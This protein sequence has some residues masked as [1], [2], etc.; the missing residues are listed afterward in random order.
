M[1]ALVVGYFSTFGDIEVLRQ[2]ERQLSAVGMPYDIHAY[3][4]RVR[5]HFRGTVDLKTATPEHYTHLLLVCGPFSRWF[6]EAY[7][8]DLDRFSHCTRV[9]VNLSMVQDLE[10]YNPLDAVIGRDSNQWARSDISFLEDV[11]K[12]PVVGL[13]LARN[14]GEYGTRQAHDTADTLLRKLAARAGCATIELDTEF[15]MEHNTSG[16]SCPEQFE[17][18]CARVDVMLTSRLHGM[19]LSLKKGT[20]VVAIDAISG[21]A[22]LS[23]QAGAIGWPE[24]FSVDSATDT[25][26]DKALERCLAPA[27]RVEAQRCALAAR[28]ALAGFS[29]EFAAALGAEPRRCSIYTPPPPRPH[30]KWPRRFCPISLGGSSG[31]FGPR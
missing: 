7:N 4:D 21:G 18:I 12:V 1:R 28:D 29:D 23:R 20:P 15:P 30:G 27:A 17:S 11:S 10:A 19:V 3:D 26:L 13:C 9:G 14:Q 16:L 22:K 2:V 25:L 6:F 31:D 5:K 8:I 24:I